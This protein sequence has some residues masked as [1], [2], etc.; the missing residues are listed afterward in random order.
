LYDDFFSVG[1][2]SLAMLQVSTQLEKRLNRSCAIVELFKQPTVSAMAAY[3]TATETT[4]EPALDV[5]AFKQRA[6]QRRNALSQ[7]KQ[8]KSRRPQ[9]D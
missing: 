8:L 6:N 9:H 5:D 1:G 4:H 2:S 3:L 7:Q